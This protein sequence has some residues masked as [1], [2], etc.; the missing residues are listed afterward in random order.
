MIKKLRVVLDTNA[1]ISSMSN[2]LNFEIVLDYLIQQKYDLFVTTE[3]LLEYEEKIMQFFD[4]DVA[5]NIL[6]LF[7]IL[8][9]IHKINIYFNQNLISVDPSDNKFVD[10]AFT[11]NVDYIVTNDKHFNILLNVTY[12]KINILSIENFVRLLN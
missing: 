7:E 9:N 3:I 11:G 5:I 6:Q 2:R 1:L 12:P 8:P 4:K 10:C